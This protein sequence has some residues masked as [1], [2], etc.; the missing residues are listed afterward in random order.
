MHVPRVGVNRMHKMAL[1]QSIS[2]SL[3]SK[4]GLI[5]LGIGIV[6]HITGF[7]VPDWVKLETAVG[8]VNS[9]LWKVCGQEVM[10]C[11]YVSDQPDWFRAVQALET[12][13]LVFEVVALFCVGWYMY[14][15][16][17]RAA[18]SCAATSFTSALS[19]IIGLIIFWARH[20]QEEDLNW[21][22]AFEVIGA[23]NCI[24]AGAL[25]AYEGKARTG[26]VS[27]G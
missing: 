20:I 24:C 5:V 16:T 23:L 15:G 11:V 3:Y 21:G 7:S 13:G 6:F 18:F 4:I 27:L 12:V 9:G 25:F 17:K 1:S 22:F 26:Y 14:R 2:G 10:G 8:P 19:T